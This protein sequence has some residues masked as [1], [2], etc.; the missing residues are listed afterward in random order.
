MHN[1]VCTKAELHLNDRIIDRILITWGKWW[2]LA[3][4][5]LR[6]AVRRSHFA[7][8]GGRQRP[9]RIMTDQQNHPTAGRRRR[10]ESPAVVSHVHDLPLPSRRDYVGADSDGPSCS[11]EEKETKRMRSASTTPR[12]ERGTHP[13]DYDQVMGASVKFGEE[14]DPETE[15]V[16]NI[17][18]CDTASLDELLTMICTTMLTLVLVRFKEDMVVL[19]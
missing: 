1:P 4:A 14:N 18:V 6:L 16:P 11:E 10:H 2:R 8:L 13:N 5:F 3:R 12:S 19:H 15:D 7:S 9:L 17:G